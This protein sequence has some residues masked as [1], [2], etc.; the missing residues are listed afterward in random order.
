[1]KNILCK[2]ISRRCFSAE[3]IIDRPLRKEDAGDLTEAFE[4]VR[5]APSAANRQPW[6]AV[7]TESGVHFYEQKS[8][9]DSPL[10]DV[11]KVDMGIAL[12]HFDLS[13]EE[14]GISGSF[15]F[16]DPELA[17]PG[18]TYYIASWKRAE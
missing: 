16:E 17:V 2:N 4:A 15:V 5:L 14:D 11:Q 1:M 3:D 18:N 13:L 8:I 10:G 9:K 7:I 12:C 6:R